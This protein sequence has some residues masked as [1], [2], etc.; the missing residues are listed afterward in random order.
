MKRF[1]LLLLVLVAFGSCKSKSTVVTTKSKGYTKTRPTVS[2]SKKIVVKTTTKPKASPTN[3]STSYKNPTADKIVKKALGFK[4]T[5]YK[6]GGLSKSGMDCSGLMH[7]A[8]KSQNISLPRTSIDQSKQGVKIAVANAQKGDLVFFK[9][10]NKNRISHVGLVIG[11]RNGEVRF[12]HASSSRG[13]MVSSLND[14]Y[15]KK[16]FSEARRVL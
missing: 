16:T 7:V 5:K 13:V 15:W 10:S 11:N 4:G 3:S 2:S 1:F 12:V 9:T 8:F 6:Y 14:G